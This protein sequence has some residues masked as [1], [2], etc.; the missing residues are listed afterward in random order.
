MFQP[1]KKRYHIFVSHSCPWAHRVTIVI[2]MKGLQDCF[3][4]SVTHPTW[5][6][7]RLDDEEDSHYGWIF[8]GGDADTFGIKSRAASEDTFTAACTKDKVNSCRTVR[9]LYDLT[10]N[11][12][13]NFT[14]PIIWDTK[15]HTIVNNESSEIVRMINDSFNEFA[16][17]PSLDLYPEAHRKAIDEVNEWIYNDI[18]NGVYKCGFARTQVYA[19]LIYAIYTLY[20]RYIRRIHNMSYS[21]ILFDKGC[22]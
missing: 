14:V 7:T 4:V 10:P 16:T 18:N 6:K 22:I 12:L 2:K 19:L 13:Q 1:E 3:D 20:T 9:D 17:N 8:N 11:N 15:T 5:G 21:Y